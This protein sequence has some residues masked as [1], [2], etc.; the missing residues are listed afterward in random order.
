MT[1]DVNKFLELLSE[2]GHPGPIR[3]GPKKF[4]FVCPACSKKA[5]KLSR[6]S[7]YWKCF[8][9][10]YI[11]QT[12]GRADKFLALALD[13]P[14][15]VAREQLY[16]SD[17]STPTLHLP[18][19]L[20]EEE[21]DEDEI[22]L[23][24]IE[25]DYHHRPIQDPKSARGVA[26][27]ESR[28]IPIDIAIQYGLRYSARER[29]VYFPVES[30]GRLVGWQGRSILP[31]TWTDPETGEVKEN[32]RLLSSPDLPRDSVLMFQDRIVD[33]YAVLVEGP[34]DCI[35]AHLVGGNCAS[36]G[37][38][39]TQGQLALLFQKGIKRLYLG[40]DPDAIEE[41]GRIARSM[42]SIEV[43][44]IDMPKGFKDLG[45]MPLE[46]ARDV[47]LSSEK[48]HPWGVFFTFGSAS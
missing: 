29:R 14:E 48:I 15:R 34:I 12:E 27:L 18:E 30:N 21:L 20:F 31:N 1:F 3:R 26:Y 8:Y 16:G 28:G 4:L 17:A 45:E 24:R 22:M 33:N 6:N 39:V 2:A 40:L 41:V 5:V 36:M 38:I 43:M 23:T 10:R 42:A 46:M 7:G 35:K 11:N 19:I 32:L 9:C 37:K 13:I 47:I 25:W 44:Y